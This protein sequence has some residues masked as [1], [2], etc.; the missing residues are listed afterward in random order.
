METICSDTQIDIEKPFKISA[1]PGSGKTRF[2]IN[3]I[4]NVLSNSKRL[5]VVNNIACITYTNIA[6]EEIKTRLKDKSARVDVSTIHSFLYRNIVKPYAYL[7]KDNKNN[8]I[9]FDMKN[10]DGHDEHQPS[11]K[12]IKEWLDACNGNNLYLYNDKNNLSVL[13]RLLSSLKY[14]FI[15]QNLIL[16]F[17]EDTLQEQKAIKF[18]SR[19]I[20]S[21]DFFDYK[22]MYWK[23]GIIDH[24]DVL[25]ISHQ[26]LKQNPILVDVLQCKYPYIFIDEFQDTNPIQTEIIKMLASP[27]CIIGVIGDYNQ[28]IYGFQGAKPEDFRDFSI[29]SLAEYQIIDNWRSTEKI[30]N[31][32]D[33]FT[34]TQQKCKRNMEGAIPN[35]IVGNLQNTLA[36][37]D[38]KEA[39]LTKSDF[40]SIILTKDNADLRNIKTNLNFQQCQSS[41]NLWDNFKIKEENKKERY[42]LISHTLKSYQ[43]AKDKNFE[44]A[45]NEFLKLFKKKPFNIIKDK[46]KQRAI[47]LEILELCINC[48]AIN[49][50]NIKEF[51]YLLKEKLKIYDIELSSYG[52][53]NA[54]TFVEKYSVE[55]ILKHLKITE[56]KTEV[57][58]I[59]GAK[60]TEYSMVS[61][62]I[63]DDGNKKAENKLKDFITNPN[64]QNEKHRR[65]F[66]ALSRAKDYLFIVIPELSKEN[67]QSIS[68]TRLYNITRV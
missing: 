42:N 63:F 60:G 2:L 44:L 40:T 1:G 67:E 46:L 9:V 54:A 7:T 13:K 58:T 12:Y 56:Y 29:E 19:R 20:Q 45:L 4:K 48:D 3:H 57:S 16:K 68:D 5:N 14:S 41:D 24:E 21:N 15:E 26:L 17:S 64:L 66:V 28:S 22:K 10:L 51:Y 25:Y 43:Y 8:I 6:V 23:E 32:L 36:F 47:S 55:D 37:I 52:K 27:K 53:G 35:I 50:K 30:I 34:G 33:N 62:F 11:F 65:K 49:K 18:P 61:L 39:E 59:H 31:T 38:E